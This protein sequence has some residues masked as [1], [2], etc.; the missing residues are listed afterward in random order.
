MFSRDKEIR[1]FSITILIGFM[2]L[3][4]FTSFWSIYFEDI[5]LKE[6]QIGF[7]Y[8]VNFLIGG[9]ATP[10]LQNVTSR[11]K[12]MQNVMPY[13]F[14]GAVISVLAFLLMD[15]FASIL[16]AVM[17]FSV[18]RIPGLSMYESQ[19][20]LF[21][22][23]KG[24]EFSRFRLY[25]SAGYVIISFFGG[26]VIELFSFQVMF[27]GSMILYIIAFILM[28]SF[29]EIKVKD[30]NVNKPKASIKTLMKN[31]KFLLFIV[32]QVLICSI[33]IVVDSFH[34]L[35]LRQNGFSIGNVGMLISVEILSEGVA[36]IIFAHMKFKFKGYM[37][38][39]AIGALVL[40]RCLSYG[41]G[42]PKGVLVL[43]VMVKGLQSAAYITFSMRYVFQILPNTDLGTGYLINTM[44]I[45]V[46]CGFA[47]FFTGTIIGE[48]SLQFIYILASIIVFCS[49]V[50]VFIGG[51][52]IYRKK[53]DQV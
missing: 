39:I 1:M 34:P 43:M 31:K 14:C 50:L 8:S 52:I 28:K 4:T 53:I 41:V 42:V 16:I 40:I 25:G 29:K 44:V 37:G 2:A 9:F 10:F 19:M 38:Q 20:A 51:K 3:S 36:L 21:A 30:R 5:G 49:M 7:I 17:V 32:G 35:F 45:N 6:S 23:E 26:Y 13:F 33:T 24:R 27:I 12:K 18:L 48:T 22:S 47:S 46:F 15:S 11:P